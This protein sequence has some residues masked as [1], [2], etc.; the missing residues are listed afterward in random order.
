MNKVRMLSVVWTLVLL[1]AL[2]AGPGMAEELAPQGTPLG[3]AFTYQGQLSRGSNLVNGTCNLRFALYDAVSGGNQ[4]GSG[5]TRTGVSVVGG[6]FTVPDLDFGI[7]AFGGEKRWLAVQVQCPGDAG[8]T[9]LSPRQALTA[10]PYAF[11]WGGQFSGPSGGIGL[12]LTGGMIGLSGIGTSAGVT[13]SSSTAS[14]IGVIGTSSGADA[15]GV[16]GST[17][18]TSGIGVRGGATASTGATFGVYGQASSTTGHGVHGYASASSGPAWG[19]WG[20]SQSTGGGGVRG[21]ASATSGSAYGVYGKSSSALGSGV[22]GWAAASSGTTYGV[23]GESASTQGRG[24]YGEASATSGTTFGVYGRS[25][26]TQGRAVYGWASATSGTT[27][28]V[29]GYA[30]SPNGY[31]VYGE[32]ALVGVRGQTSHSQGV[33]VMGYNTSTTGTT[34][35]V[36]GGAHSPS[37][38]GV[39]G[40][41]MSTTGTAAGVYGSADSPSGYGVFGKANATGGSGVAGAAAASNANYGVYSYGN[42]AASGT[43]AAV[44][45]TQD[46]GWRHLYAVESPQ[47]L[48]E[49]VGTAQLVSGKAEVGID[50]IFAQ[51][52]NLAQPYQVFLTPL[53]D[54]GLYVAE[55]TAASFTVHAL[56][57]RECSVAFDY[58]IIAQRLGY[59]T[60]RLATA[61]DPA[62]MVQPAREGEAQ[63]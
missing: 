14:G 41:N 20:Q 5:L 51:T 32:G 27:Y 35:G 57:G 46:Y 49:D 17:T 37:G 44:V 62:L 23:R 54:C 56:D 10:P 13:G 61:A 29:Y 33:G 43:K 26:S 53:G 34:A 36:F 39:L 16:V 58:R 52:V 31:G 11:Y 28:G 63:P 25:S 59:E 38:Y 50:P 4:V 47:V 15:M 60:M 19:V 18:S 48:F 9:A 2:N 22:Y 6:L 45:Q 12:T 24:V 8:F 40:R 55:K 30:A 42:F 1:L 3:S 21:E 7:G